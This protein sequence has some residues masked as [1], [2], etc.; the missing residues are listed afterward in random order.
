MAK[1]VSVTVK[2]VAR[3]ARVSVATVS[4]VL[5]GKGSALESTRQRVLKAA[6][7]LGYVPHYGA[8]SLITRR[9][10]T[11]GVLLPDLYGEFYSEVIR[12]IDHAAGRRGFHVLVSSS[13]SDR[14]ELSAVLGAMRGRVD[15]LLL[16]SP[17]L[18]AV[19]LRTDLPA[20]VPVV[21]LNCRAVGTAYDSVNLDNYRGAAAMVAHLHAV[22]HR[23]IALM[24]G[25][26]DNFDARERLRGYR[27][28]LRRLGAYDGPGLELPGDFRE[29]SGYEAARRLLGMAERPTAVFA[30]NDSMAIGLLSALADSG[31]RVPQDI[32]VTGFDDIPVSRFLRPPLTTVHV[33][34]AEMGTR[35][36]ELLLH[37]VQ[38]GAA[39]KGRREVMEARLVVRESCGFVPGATGEDSVERRP[40]RRP[41]K[42]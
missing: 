13:H 37:Q 30:A 15:G 34:I 32:A 12:G 21:L 36:V 8:R 19:D 22:G 5:N 40:R 39:R 17:A 25:P 35:A 2:Q 28:A 11:L 23:R 9:T 18:D 31:V 20:A 42:G 14:A 26:T 38:E 27:T 41:Q 16:M 6:Q 4:R 1:A 29:S 3:R 7:A 10:E 24:R 33:P